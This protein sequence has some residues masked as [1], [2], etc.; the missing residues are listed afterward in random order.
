MPTAERSNFFGM[1]HGFRMDPQLFVSL[2][3][4]NE[5][6]IDFP[7]RKN[8]HTQGKHSKSMEKRGVMEFF[9]SYLDCLCSRND[10]SRAFILATWTRILSMKSFPIYMLVLSKEVLTGIVLMIASDTSNCSNLALINSYKVSRC[11][12]CWS[13][14]INSF[15]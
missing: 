11:S 4:D 2:F 6:L 8:K 14:A 12:C 13:D 1:S 3:Q 7:I 9:C 10:I 15:R 5:V